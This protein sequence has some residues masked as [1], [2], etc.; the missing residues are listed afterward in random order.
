MAT[1]ES[2]DPYSCS[3]R[4]RAIEVFDCVRS[5]KR[6]HFAEDGTY[7]FELSSLLNTISVSST[8]P[9]GV[10]RSSR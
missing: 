5:R 8:Q 6:P 1:D 9:Y 4:L 3:D 10:C 7:Y 2:K